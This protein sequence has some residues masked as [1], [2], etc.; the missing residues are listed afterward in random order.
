M[1]QDENMVVNPGAG[2]GAAPNRKAAPISHRQRSSRFV[3]LSLLVVALIAG[4]F[5]G[6]RYLQDQAM[7]VSTENALITGALIQVGSLNA[8]QVSSV[9]VDIGDR[10]TKGQVVAVVALPVS[11]GAT[12]AGTQKMGFMS[13]DDQQV[14]VRSPIDGVVAARS[15]NPG[16]TVAA[17]QPLLT[18]IDPTQFWVQAQI[19]E[20]KIARLNPGQPVAVTVDTLGKQV[21]GR[22]VAVG[23]ATAATF[24]LLPQGNT[25]GNYTKVTQL[26]PVKIAIDYQDLPLVL[27]S[28]VEVKIRVKE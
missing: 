14:S 27:G 7:H 3:L 18:V 19:E 6:Y 24:S 28:S 2:A 16:D 23:S 9:A 1:V 22:V 12:G 26:V 4:G 11:L 21:Q 8:G 5:F 13:T 20:T 25:S 17:G 10:V 15:S